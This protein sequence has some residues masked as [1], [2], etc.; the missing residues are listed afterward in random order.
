[1]RKS[2]YL[3]FLEYFFKI[4]KV[5]SAFNLIFDIIGLGSL[6]FISLNT[7]IS[8]PIYA[9]FTINK[10]AYSCFMALLVYDF[11]YVITLTGFIDKIEDQSD[12]MVMPLLS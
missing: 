3:Q 7:K 9:T 8:E 10:C 2:L 4:K 11:F 1:M 6:I 5:H 12:D